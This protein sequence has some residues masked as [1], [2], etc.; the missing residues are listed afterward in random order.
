MKQLLL[1]FLIVGFC[2]S[3]KAPK[4]SHKAG[5]EFEFFDITF[6]S[7]VCNGSC[8]DITMSIDSRKTVQLIRQI[9]TRKGVVDQGRSGAFKGELS[10][11]DFDKLIAL[12]REIDWDRLDWPSVMCCDLPVKTIMLGI[13]GQSRNFRSMKW[14]A[15]ANKLIDFLTQLGTNVELPAYDGPM[16]F[17]SIGD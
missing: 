6:Y 10:Q 13:N 5:R 11:R 3:C 17:E 12:I 7:S 16:D 4:T 9:F 14:P 8:P 2:V 15:E 1:F